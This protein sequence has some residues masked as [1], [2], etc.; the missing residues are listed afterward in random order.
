MSV[1][2]PVS[3][4]SSSNHNMDLGGCH[5]V[6]RAGY[7]FSIQGIMG[8][9]FASRGPTYIFFWLEGSDGLFWVWN[10]GQKRFFWVYE[11]C[12]YFFGSQKKP[13]IFLG[14]VLFTSSNQ[15]QCKHNLLLVWD[16]F[17]LH[18]KNDRDFFG[19]TNSEVWIFFGYKIWTSVGLTPPPPIIKISEWGP[20]AFASLW[21]SF[22]QSHHKDI[23]KMILSSPRYRKD[24][25]LHV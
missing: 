6:I 3:A 17:R 16:Y 20:W 19:L 13:G 12:G 4:E 8:T 1:S 2:I 7:K 14:I 5:R 18:V 25:Q 23:K 15:Q 21:R 24:C 10:F 9:S 11:W 22:G